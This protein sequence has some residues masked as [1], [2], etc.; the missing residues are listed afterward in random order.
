ML[1]AMAKGAR[2]LEAKLAALDALR[3]DPSGEASVT[4][5]RAALADKDNLVAAKAAKIARDGEVAALTHDLC[6]SFARMMKSR[7]RCR[8]WR[9]TGTTRG[10]PKASSGRRSGIGG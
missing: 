8:R 1:S 10:Y 6:D 2:N 3:D 4:G 5:L 7:T 9:C